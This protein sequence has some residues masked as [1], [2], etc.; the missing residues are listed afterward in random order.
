MHH[1]NHYIGRTPDGREL[2]RYRIPDERYAR[3]REFL[4]REL[5]GGLARA[6]REVCA[7]F[8]VFAAE[9]WR[10]EHVRGPWTWDGIKEAVGVGSDPYTVLAK[11]VDMGLRVLGRPLLTSAGGERERLLTVACE[12]GLPLRRLQVEG[13]RLPVYFRDVLEDLEA[14]GMSGQEDGAALE[15]V[16]ARYDYRLPPSLRRGIV[17]R[18][19]G[20]LVGRAWSLRRALSSGVTNPVAVLDKEIPEWREHLPLVVSDDSAEALLRGLMTDVARV[21]SGRGTRLRVLASLLLEDETARLQRF[22]DAPSSLTEDQVASAFEGQVLPTG[23]RLQIRMRAEAGDTL[24]CGVLSRAGEQNW[25]F[26]PV[27]GAS[28]TGDAATQ[29]VTVLAATRGGAVESS[30]VEGGAPLGPLPWVFRPSAGTARRWDLV[31][32]GS[33]RRREPELLIALPEG[34][35]AQGDF[36]AEVRTVAGRSLIRANGEVRIHTEAGLVRVVADHATNET[37]M[38]EL[39]GRRFEKVTSSRTA[40]LGMPRLVRRLGMRK[41][42]ADLQV[43]DGERWRRVVGTE[44][45]ELQ[46]RSLA[47]GEVVFRDRIRVVPEDLTLKLEI[48]DRGRAG[49]ITVASSKLIQAGVPEDPRWTSQVTKDDGATRI[50]MSATGEVP[51]RVALTMVFRD[52]QLKGAVPFPERALHFE[53][54]DGD[55]IEWGAQFH[56][57]RLGGVRAVALSP[58]PRAQFAV[59]L[60][61][62]SAGTGP[63][64]AER[65]FP[66]LEQP[67]GEKILDLRDVQSAAL[68]ILDATESLDA[69]VRIRLWEVGGWG[70]SISIEAKRY[71]WTLQRDEETGDVVLVGPDLEAVDD[72]VVEARSFCEV[73]EVQTLPRLRSARLAEPRWVFDPSA[74]SGCTW[75]VTAREGSWY[76]CRPVPFWGRGE[77][78][79]LEGLRACFELPQ[80]GQ[81]HEQIRLILD[82]MCLNWNHSDWAV[83]DGYLRMLGDLPATTFDLIRVIAHHPCAA[84]IVALRASGWGSAD[85]LQVMDGLEELVFL[86]EAVP[87]AT[88][89]GAFTTLA[90]A[91]PAEMVEHAFGEVVA[92]AKVIGAEYPSVLVALHHW[93][94][95]RGQAVPGDVDPQVPVSMTFQAHNADDLLGFCSQA[96]DDLLRRHAD[97]HAWPTPPAGIELSSAGAVAVAESHQDLHR[98]R[99]ID[100]PAVLARAAVGELVLTMGETLFLEE[101]RSFDDAYFRET[102]LFT[103]FALVARRHGER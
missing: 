26:Q 90:G 1:L 78:P 47:D 64:P 81:R 89:K 17:H 32:C 19:V 13:A 99:V 103:F 41:E 3:L 49:A 21:A 33:T 15:D 24:R 63:G 56:I 83:V 93:A 101:V 80:E 73:G 59:T 57:K 94:R 23:N 30:S 87:F 39:Q 2:Y 8:C 5:R 27:R 100:A 97:G 14:L 50:E 10:R 36:R 77:P 96:A 86:W 12:G 60:Q 71:D 29:M 70:R 20:E 76:R 25:S 88:W 95:D 82:H 84:A 91:L 43:R 42:L 4:R 61:P 68:E 37:A 31:A 79:E 54:P 98:R 51:S 65:T 53:T 22:L 92:R 66:L 72:V 102:F 28:F 34:A 18:L 44:V 16:A 62:V 35:V 67:T 85:F 58:N 46:V 52:G 6:D 11:A 48:G 74:R 40:W 55:T 7:L 75:L 69:S 45:G 38:Y 9:W